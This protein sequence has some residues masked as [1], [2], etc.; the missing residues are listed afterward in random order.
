MKGVSWNENPG[1]CG[2]RD[3]LC[4]P[5]TRRAGSRASGPFALRLSPH[6]KE[7]IKTARNAGIRKLSGSRRPGKG[8][9]GRLFPESFLIPLLRPARR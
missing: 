4:N 2:V 5:V 3:F 8:R 6:A 7:K 9:P 1:G